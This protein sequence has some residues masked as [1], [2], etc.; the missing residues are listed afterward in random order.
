LIS[1]RLFQK[2]FFFVQQCNNLELARRVLWENIY[3]SLDHEKHGSAVCCVVF[4]FKVGLVSIGEEDFPPT[5]E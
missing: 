2:C 4:V 5:E 3:V 1:E